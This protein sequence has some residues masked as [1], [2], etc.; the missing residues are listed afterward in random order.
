MLFFPL[1]AGQN[2]GKHT[3]SE[4]LTTFIFVSFDFRCFNH[5]NANC[6]WM[7]HFI[8]ILWEQQRRRRPKNW[9]CVRACVR[10]WWP[11]SN[12]DFGISLLFSLFTF[13]FRWLFN[14]IAFWM[15]AKQWAV[16]WW[17]F[18]I[19]VALTF[20]TSFSSHSYRLESVWLASLDFAFVC[21]ISMNL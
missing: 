15:C 7:E 12:R 10:C 3:V 14:S 9:Y 1:F 6:E 4:K 8:I 5:I 20:F 13:I 16:R 18:S 21:V 19:S 2:H 11:S 17:P